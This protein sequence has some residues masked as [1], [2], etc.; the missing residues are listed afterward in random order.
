V[1]TGKDS[2]EVGLEVKTEKAKQ[3]FMYWYQKAGQ[4]N[5][6]N[7]SNKSFKDMAKCRY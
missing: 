6:V 3:M 1:W 5:N 7:V 4:N 2:R